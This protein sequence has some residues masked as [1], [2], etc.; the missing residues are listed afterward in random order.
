[1][2]GLPALLGTGTKIGQEKPVQVV[3]S[4]FGGIGGYSCVCAWTTPADAATLDA[5]VSVDRPAPK[6]GDTVTLS[7]AVTGGT[8]PYKY[9]VG[10]RHG[11]GRGASV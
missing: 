2:D 11:R 7:A 3:H 9:L 10:R 4:G 8:A 6:L 1:M 5:T